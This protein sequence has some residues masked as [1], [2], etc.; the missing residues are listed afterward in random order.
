MSTASP[1]DLPG[2]VDQQ[3]GDRPGDDRAVDPA[4]DRA[5]DPVGDRAVDP[6]EA[7]V[8]DWMTVY[9]TADTLRTSPNRVRQLVREHALAMLRTEGSREPR[10]PTLMVA[11]GQVVKGLGGT[12]T[13][14]SDAGYD[15]REAVAWL[16]APDDALGDRPIDALRANRVHEVHRLAQALGF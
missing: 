11:D 3:Q 12:L 1:D 16:F 9:E 15:L 10:V 2:A 6:L 14:L 8:G 5:G 4:G 13:L 7:L